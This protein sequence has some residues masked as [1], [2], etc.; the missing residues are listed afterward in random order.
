MLSS[1]LRHR[2]DIQELVID[3]DSETGAQIEAWEDILTDEPAE[4]V[5]LS[6]REFIAADAK[7]AGV[8]ARMTVRY[9][10][11]V[12]PSMRVIHESSYYQIRAVLPDPTNR[13]HITLMCE[14]GVNDGN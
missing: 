2:I 10:P 1:K 4:I 12:K 13:R 7:Q 8:V 11:G 3:Q 5:P 9:H 6:G 14:V